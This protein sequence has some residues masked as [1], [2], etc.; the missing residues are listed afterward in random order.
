MHSYF[1]LTI[2]LIPF[3]TAKAQTS[4][5]SPN[6]VTFNIAA[7]QLGSERKIWLYLPYNYSETEKRFPV[8]C[9]HDGQNLFD[10]N[11]AFAGEWHIDEKLDSMKAETIVVGI[12]HGNEKRIDELTPYENKKYGGGHADK[13]LDFI[14]NTLLP[15]IN[16]NYRTKTNRENTIMMGSSVG[17]LL[18]FYALLKYPK[19]FGKA[20]VFSP[21]FWF[22][23]ELYNLVHSVER[24]NSK[25]YFMAGDHESTEMIPDLDRMYELVLFKTT[26]KKHIIKKIVHNGRHNG[27]LWSNE[28]ADAYLWLTAN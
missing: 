3:M 19:V 2:F 10:N 13:Y 11:S 8:L 4:S 27:T 22:S 9:M 1:L 15:Y 14:V 17:G 24:I 16:E 18:S 6:V 26:D 28:F 20:G 23:E 7:P 21:S 5:A 12:E 25:I